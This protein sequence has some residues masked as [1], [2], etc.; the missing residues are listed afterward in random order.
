MEP[1]ASLATVEHGTDRDA[2][3]ER[4]DYCCKTGPGERT[5]ELN[6]LRTLGS[7]FLRNGWCIT[8]GMH[9]PTDEHAL[10]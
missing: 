10:W 2:S 6:E 7:Q 5:T 3:I 8:N 9:P 1:C 4:I